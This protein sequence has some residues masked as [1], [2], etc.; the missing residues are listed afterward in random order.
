MVDLQDRLE[1]A[2]SDR[3][4]VERELGH[5]GMAIVYLAEDRKHHRRVAIKVL[6]PELAQAVGAERFL[7]E[8]AIAGQLTHPNLLPLHDSGHI[9]GLL[10]YV[11]PFVEGES[12]R[13]RLS[14]DTQLPFEDV[15]TISREVADALA[16][17]HARGLI[18]RDIKP[19]NVLLQAGHAV[20]S[21]FGIARAIGAAGG[22]RLTETGL[23]VGTPAY[24]SP[25]QASGDQAIDARSD[26][27]SLGCLVYEMLAGEPPYTGATP[28]AILARKVVEPVPSL[29][30]VRDTVPLAVEQVVTKALAKVPA[31]RFTTAAQFRDALER[32]FASSEVATPRPL[33]TRPRGL[34]LSGML[35]LVLVGGGWWVSKLVT[36]VGTARIESLAVLPLANLSG[37]AEQDYFAAGMH[38]ALITDLAKLGA[39]KRVIARASV[40]RYRNTEEPLP[41]VARELGVD[42]IVTGSVL[43]DGNRL[44][45]TA[46]LINAATQENLWA[47]RYEREVR[48]VLS[49]QNEIVIAITQGIKLQLPPETRAR[50]AS[51][52]AV[53]PEAYE[54]YL[55]GKFYL[56]KFTPEGFEKGLTFLHEAIAKDSTDPLSYAALALGYSLI[57]HE[58]MPDAF[59]RARVAARKASE[60]GG[61]LAETQEAFAE[62]K[63]YSEW[64]WAGSQEYFQRA[65]A[66][67]PSL[68][69]AHAH[70]S[71]YLQLMG[72][73]DE[74]FAEM[75]RAEDVDPLTPLWP[76]WLAW[77]YWVAGQLDKGIDEARKSLDLNPDFPWG[78]FIL[79]VLY[80]E[81]GMHPEAIEAHLK[82]TRSSP[83]VKWG[84]GRTYAQA[85]RMA[86]ARQIAAELTKD[87]TPMNAWGLAVIHAALGEKDQAFR[88]LDKAVDLRFS[89]VPWINSDPSLAPLRTDPRF[90]ELARRLKVP[91]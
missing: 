64:D 1:R 79:G 63:L 76:A 50:L 61:T 55:K 35:A 40:M 26:V 65:L 36:R 42:L 18:H 68:P 78:L 75:L 25:E 91:S 5:G 85:G 52:R 44:R 34:A 87:V 14:R 30:V 81:K 22:D 15:L 77:Q 69:E 88:W 80:A 83:A 20:V 9:D 43:R 27:Y 66:L 60:L 6:R 56:N 3:Y 8:I 32:A 31:D 45:V 37:N 71:W 57:G 73:R 84:L 11:M 10:Y 41:Q 24:M 46:Q 19:E 54:A 51:A 4:R 67:N 70:Y 2:L 29:R 53:N 28:Q 23:A 49:L 86:E 62:N 89:W 82:A 38:E 16:F 17:A 12:L 59:K 47:D 90:Q 7:R 13:D 33:M 74:A 58:A 72:R 39:F 48:E 21:D